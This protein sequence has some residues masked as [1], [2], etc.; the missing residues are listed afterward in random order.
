MIKGLHHVGFQV[1]NLEESIKYYESLGFSEV[2]RFEYEE[3]EFQGVMLKA[4]EYGNIELFKFNN[5]DHELVEKIKHHTA[6]ETDDME[7]DI[8]SFLD[9]GCEVAMP[10]A[11]GKIVKRRV[12]IKD[13]FDN[14]IEL[15]EPA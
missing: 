13:K 9:Q 1:D 14:Y 4:L 11:E 8:Q 3:A 7:A 15:L 2:S 12:Y 5:P 6:F 10:L